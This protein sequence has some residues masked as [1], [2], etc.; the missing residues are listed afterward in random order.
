MA[1]AKSLLCLLLL[2]AAGLAGAGEIILSPPAGEAGAVGGGASE[3]RQRAKTYRKS[4]SPE[5]GTTIILMPEDE[6][7]GMMSPR[8]GVES[9]RAAE[10]RLRAKVLRQSEDGRGAPATIIIPGSG[11]DDEPSH[12]RARDNRL[13]AR[14]YRD[15]G[16]SALDKVGPDGV[17]WVL[18]TNTESVAGRIG[19]DVQSGSLIYIIRDGKPVKAR[20][21]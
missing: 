16:Q 11:G 6:G 14:V 18:C 12:D 13:K 7:E 3:Q 19:D 8:G 21:R 2:S 4:Q 17:P 5:T 10:N 20:C 1:M 15:H 9:S